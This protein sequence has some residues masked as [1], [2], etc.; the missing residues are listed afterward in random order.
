MVRVATET[1]GASLPNVEF[2]V[3]D[4]Q[5]LDLRDE[6]DWVFSNS[7][8]HWVPDHPAVLR[9]VARALRPGGRLSFSMG[10]RGTA[11]AVY[12]VL[13][14]FQ[15]EGRWA[16][17]IADV[18]APHHFFGPEEYDSWLAQAGLHSRRVELIP[19]PMH[20]A[21]VAAL[22]GWIRTTWTPYLEPIPREHRDGFLA[23]LAAG[24]LDRCS[25]AEDG[26]ILLPMVNLEVEAEKLAGQ[27]GIAAAR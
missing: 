15:R 4:A 21:D 14:E 3:A 19:K 18:A 6:F 1:W 27:Q 10:G 20:H 16:P 26:A 5:A 17:L 22:Q 8:L 23:E 24:I 9:G 12:Q 25:T 13:A 7:T 11:A 2:R